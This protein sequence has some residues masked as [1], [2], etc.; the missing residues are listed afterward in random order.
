MEYIKKST[1]FGQQRNNFLQHRSEKYI[2]TGVWKIQSL[3]P[4]TEYTSAKEEK[5][6]EE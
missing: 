5:M 4:H 1:L 6:T 3:Y 2:K